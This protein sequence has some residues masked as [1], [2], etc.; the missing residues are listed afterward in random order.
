MA[1][2]H[3][4]GGTNVGIGLAGGPSHTVIE[5]SC[6]PGG[7]AV[8]AGV[9]PPPPPPQLGIM[10]MTSRS[11]GMRRGPRRHICMGVFS[12]D[13]RS[14]RCQEWQ[15]VCS[16]KS[17]RANGEGGVSPLPAVAQM[18]VF[19][20]EARAPV[21]GEACAQRRFGL[22]TAYCNL[23]GLLRSD[24]QDHAGANLDR[25]QGLLGRKIRAVQPRTPQEASIGAIPTH[26][27]Y[28]AKGLRT[29]PGMYDL[30]TRGRRARGSA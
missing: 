28:R 3:G 27:N 17:W 9:A 1:P 10:A 19:K 22:V 21:G 4:A 30:R 2:E 7:F 26:W 16:G 11:A 8:A 20:E 24:I 25:K 15:F 6:G 14:R 18:R 13:G 23:D 5:T 12:Y 29:L